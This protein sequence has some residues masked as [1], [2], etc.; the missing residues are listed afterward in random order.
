MFRQ[1]EMT[2]D[3]VA[4][5]IDDVDRIALRVWN[6]NAVGKILDGGAQQTGRIGRVDVSSVEYGRHSGQR[7]RSL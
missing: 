7:S 5:G 3:F 4:G 2:D 1:R 6:V